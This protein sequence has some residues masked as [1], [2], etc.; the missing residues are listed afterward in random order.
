MHS[1]LRE[2]RSLQHWDIVP[3]LHWLFA[4]VWGSLNPPLKGVALTHCG[5]FL[6][7]SH[8]GLK[9]PVKTWTVAFYPFGELSVHHEVVNVLLCFGEFQLSGHHGHH[10]GST[11]R[12][13]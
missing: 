6:T 9:S 3:I 8:A 2:D 12:T 4:C 1:D 5:Y 13:L 7:G 10:Q 11:A